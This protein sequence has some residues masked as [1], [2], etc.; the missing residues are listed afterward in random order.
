MVKSI[1]S[2]NDT[3]DQSVMKFLRKTRCETVYSF[4][5]YVRR[6]L[7]LRVALAA[8]AIEKLRT[9]FNKVMT[10]NPDSPEFSNYVSDIHVEQLD[11]IAHIFMFLEDFLS[12]SRVLRKSSPMNISKL[13]DYITYVGQADIDN[14]ARYLYT[15]KMS[16]VWTEFRFPD[17]K[18]LR[19][20]DGKSLTGKECLLLNHVLRNVCKE[21]KNR[22]K[23]ILEFRENYRQVYNKYKHGLSII[24][25]SYQ[26]QQT[27]IGR[28]IMSHIYIRSKERGRKKIYTY[29]IPTG[30]DILDYY[31]KIVHYAHEVT[32]FLVE[33]QFYYF[34]NNGKPFFPAIPNT[35]MPTN[36]DRDKLQ[37]L[38]NDLDFHKVDV[39]VRT[40]ITVVPQ[41][42]KIAGK[43]LKKKYVYKLPSDLLKKLK[44]GFSKT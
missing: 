33:Y 37:Q 9:D 24:V 17:V 28:N 20:K 4:L 1:M 44:V 40:N 34:H 13:A 42:T 26:V 3:W 6:N 5:Y 41:R 21:I 27:T 32:W 18:Q 35:M 38:V 36:I 7:D 22:L 8:T 30:V 39:T 10:I 43:Y 15:L 23:V 19:K 2:K 25:G 14:E 12:Y 29:M 16:D 11:L 31:E